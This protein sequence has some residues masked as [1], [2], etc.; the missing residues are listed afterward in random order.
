[1]GQN[2]FGFKVVESF[3]VFF[4]KGEVAGGYDCVGGNRDAISQ[5]SDV[6]NVYVGFVQFKEA[7]DLADMGI[8]VVQNFTF[9]GCVYGDENVLPR[10]TF[11]GD[12]DPGFAGFYPESNV[13]YFDNFSSRES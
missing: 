12:L 8:G 11:G 3:E 4:Y 7:V 5:F 9:V 6:I 1:M 10:G 13:V 2:V